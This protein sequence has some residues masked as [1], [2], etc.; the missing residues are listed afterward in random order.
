M[1]PKQTLIDVEQAISDGDFSHAGALLREYRG[2][3]SRGGFEPV[4]EMQAPF[5]GP[6]DNVADRLAV[7]LQEREQLAVRQ[8]GLLGHAEDLRFYVIVRADGSRYWIPIR[9]SEDSGL[10]YEEAREEADGDPLYEVT[11]RGTVIGVECAR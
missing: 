8:S 7:H 5:T 11:V 1:D 6:G 9:E 10:A 4:M 3:R 2:W